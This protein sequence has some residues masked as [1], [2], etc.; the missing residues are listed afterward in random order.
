M[1]RG[2]VILAACLKKRFVFWY[3]HIRVRIP[4]SFISG[5]LF[6]CG[7]GLL[8]S[9]GGLGG[10]W[11]GLLGCGGA[12]LDF[13]GVLWGLLPGHD[14]GYLLRLLGLLFFQHME[15]ETRVISSG[16]VRGSKNGTPN[17][18]L[19]LSNAAI[20]RCRSAEVLFFWRYRQEK[21]WRDWLC[22]FYDPNTLSQEVA[23]N[24]K[25]E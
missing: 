2:R 23:R 4:H 21:L 16:N 8:R 7:R 20:I 3:H 14:E 24:V 11:R 10:F 9:G 17:W 5:G 6:G 22:L 12:L 18:G 13:G 15:S 1:C 25:R 19:R